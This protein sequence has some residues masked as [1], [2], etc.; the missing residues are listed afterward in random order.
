MNGKRPEKSSSSRRRGRGVL[1]TGIL[2]VVT[3]GITAFM[4]IWGF[5]L[6]LKLIGPSSF[7]YLHVGDY[8]PVSPEAAELAGQYQLGPDRFGPIKLGM[9][10]AEVEATGKFVYRRKLPMRG[11]SFG[12]AVGTE[13][14]GGGSVVISDIYGVSKIDI[15][16]GVRTPEGIGLGSSLDQVRLTYR[17]TKVET[18]SDVGDGGLEMDDH[19]RTSVPG[20]PKASYRIFVDKN[21][22]VDEL[23]LALN[24]QNC[25]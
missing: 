16:Q 17:D 25:Y 15:Y 22:N 5:G 14:N 23:I 9:S 7:S 19:Y 21:Q 6:F 11:C 18:G 4:P 24:V 12:Q 20:N 1:V 13:V 8:G 10:R 2:V 3:V